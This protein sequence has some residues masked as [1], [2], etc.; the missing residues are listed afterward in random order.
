MAIRFNPNI[1]PVA[2][3][4]IF[5]LSPEERDALL[6]RD[7]TKIKEEIIYFRERSRDL[8]AEVKREAEKYKREKDRL[9]RILTDEEAK[10]ADKRAEISNLDSLIRENRDMHVQTLKDL[11]VVTGKEYTEIK[12]R[13]DDEKARVD[14]IN[15]D[16]KARVDII[17]DFEKNESEYLKTLADLKEQLGIESKKIE[18]ELE[19]QAEQRRMHHE[20]MQVKVD[21]ERTVEK[22]RTDLE[23]DRKTGMWELERDKVED[24]KGI[25]ETRKLSQKLSDKHREVHLQALVSK[26]CLAEYQTL[27]YKQAKKIKTLK[28]ELQYLKYNLSEELYKFSAEVE[29]LKRERENTEAD[30]EEKINSLN[31]HVDLKNRELRNL[32]FL[33]K[34]TLHQKNMLDNFLLESIDYTKTMASLEGGQQSGAGLQGA[35]ISELSWE[36]REKLLRL[37][38]SKTTLG[39][40]PA[41]WRRLE[42]EERKRKQNPSTLPPL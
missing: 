7:I 4:D 41:Y 42:A 21:E 13:L 33:A 34:A 40:T 23:N 20:A 9:A 17:D 15:S 30:Y 16:L 11:E 31:D 22:Q 2:E 29:G 1:Y 8:L 38:F 39:V 3:R 6:A 26:D 28:A 24:Q 10:I 37:L 14:A 36:E 27:N 18:V 5:S 25:D 19:A 35:E 12:K 32:R